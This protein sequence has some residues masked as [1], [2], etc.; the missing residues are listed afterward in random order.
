MI[1]IFLQMDDTYF[2]KAFSNYVSNNCPELE[3]LCFTS[4]EKADEFLK[5]N[6][7][8]LDAIIG[9]ERFI[10]GCGLADVICLTVSDHTAFSNPE[11]MRLNVYQAGRDIV[12]DIKSALA[13]RKGYLHTLSGQSMKNVVALF[14]QQ[15]GS[16]K[17]TIAYALALTAVRQGKQAMYL[18]LEPVP[19]VGQLYNH[20]FRHSMDDLLFALKDGRELAPVMLDTLERNEAGVLIL[21]PVHSTGDLLSLTQE[22]IRQIVQVLVENAGIDYLLI[23]LPCGLYPLNA[24]V[25]QECTTILQVYSD[26]ECGRTKMRLAQSDLYYQE[27]PIK[28]M[29]L[30]VMN[31]CRFSAADNGVAASIPFSES[32]QQ[33]RTVGQV[34]ESN[35]AYLNSFMALLQKLR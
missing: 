28:G 7:R 27:L 26:D 2:V 18:N 6:T 4:V 16:G 23:D 35:P 17:T 29:N 14:S 20:V 30:P 15:G 5:G 12:A 32:L 11:A 1:R 21:P 31:K 24:W 13:L 25:L 9:E 8:R 34:Q 22:D 33:G 19:Y 10:A 3:F